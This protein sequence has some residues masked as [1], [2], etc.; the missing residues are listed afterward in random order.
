M[1]P[2]LPFAAL[3]LVACTGGVAQIDDSDSEDTDPVED[4]DIGDTDIED[5][6]ANTEPMPGRITVTANGLIGHF[7]QMYLVFASGGG[8]QQAPGSYCETVSFDPDT[9]SGTVS[10]YAGDPCT[11]GAEIDFE[12]GEWT[13][14]G[15]VYNPGSQTPEKCA[16]V[17]ITVDGDVEVMMPPL[18]DC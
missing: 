13:L 3:F 4:T 2:T 5:T 9:I 16:E 14:T 7:G 18:G 1:R 10:E 8:E 12:P 15:G 11:L 6:D 17:T